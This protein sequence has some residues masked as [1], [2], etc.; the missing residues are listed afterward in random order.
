MR[1]RRFAASRAR[2]SRT[3]CGRLLPSPRLKALIT[4]WSTSGAPLRAKAAVVGDIRGRPAAAA[5]VEG[6]DHAWI[7]ARRAVAREG[8]EFLRPR[9][10]DIQPSA[11][12]PARQ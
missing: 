2:F 12:A 1:P 5:K 7:A 11:G 4:T 10:G 3:I 6:L 9:R 8:R